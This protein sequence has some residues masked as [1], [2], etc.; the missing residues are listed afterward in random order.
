MSVLTPTLS[1]LRD[2]ANECSIKNHSEMT[3][4]NPIAFRQIVTDFAK[5]GDYDAETGICAKLERE[6]F[7]Q[8]IGGK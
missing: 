7:C 3:S 8:R 6:H 5:R 1:S 4:A 2:G